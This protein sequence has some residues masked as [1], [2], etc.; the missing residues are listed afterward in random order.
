[1]N[2]DMDAIAER[3][4]INL[5][6]ALIEAVEAEDAILPA[7]VSGPDLHVAALEA[8]A[9]VAVDFILSAPHAAPDS[10]RHVVD[11]MAQRIDDLRVAAR[12]AGPAPMTH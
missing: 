10:A 11:F 9:R 5:G 1:M 3:L 6:L 12:G 4:R 2:H 8:L 7:H